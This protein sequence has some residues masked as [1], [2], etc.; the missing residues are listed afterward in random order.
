MSSVSNCGDK[1]IVICS[2]TYVNRKIRGA[3]NTGKISEGMATKKKNP[4]AVKLGRKGGKK[5]AE[6]LSAE[7]L[8]EQGRKA[9]IARWEKARKAGKK[10]PERESE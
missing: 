2:A 4:A 9:V 10:K 7:Q 1:K 5:R 8:S 3:K 6:N